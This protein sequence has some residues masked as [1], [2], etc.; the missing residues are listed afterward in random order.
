MKFSKSSQLF[1]V[2][3]I[4]LL[5]ATVLTA[6][7]ITTIDY[8]Y[9]ASAAA[10]GSS[11]DGQ[12]ET[13]AVDSQSGALRTVAAVV[14]SGGANPVAMAVTSDYA[15]LYVANAGSSSIVH[16]SVGLDGT[17]T[18]KD[19]LPLGSRPTA[20]AVNTAGTYL[21]VVSG[22]DSSTLTE[23]ALSSGTIGSQTAQ[24]KLSL[25]PI[26]AGYGGDTL[27]ATGVAV[28]ADNTTIHGNGVFV[29]VYDQSA[30]NPAAPAGTVFSTANPGWVFGFTIGSDGALTAATASGLPMIWQ[31]G[32]K[33]SALAADPTDRFL[34]VTDYASNELIGYTILGGNN[35]SFLTN[36]PFKTGNEPAALAIDPTGKFIYV[37]NALDSTISAF[38]ITLANGTPTVV[39]GTAGTQLNATDTEPVAI[40]I[41]PALGRYVY[42]ANYLGNSVSG[43]RLD[44][45]S[46]ALTGTQAAPYPS[47]G[48][49]PAALVVVP[50]GN[51]ATQTVVP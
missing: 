50:H 18:S 10:S 47:T 16:L 41:D 26:S 9:V 21:Y 24:E 37:T 19:T 33:P 22:T 51:H 12:I 8:V 49:E 39:L 4:G 13:Y 32:V 46:G 3:S 14:S 11:G 44:P 2:S 35:L 28:L 30:Y 17:L 40:A 36:G 25:S 31:A 1:L 48:S 38:A 15:N 5:V 43:F 29:S 20:L 42:S 23:Y 6:C 7:S 34:Y 45:T 27:I